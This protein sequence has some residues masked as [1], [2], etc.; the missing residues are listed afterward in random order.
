MLIPAVKV[1][2]LSPHS[3]NIP[4]IRAIVTMD[5][6]HSL[7]FSLFEEET[8]CHKYMVK[9]NLCVDYIYMIHRAPSW[10]CNKIFQPTLKNAINPSP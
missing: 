7:S 1:T 4:F 10:D 2:R 9:K 8:K 6:V 5:T 3:S